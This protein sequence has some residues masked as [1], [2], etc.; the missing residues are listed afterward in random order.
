MKIEICEQ[1]VQ[2]WLINYMN[3][4]VAQ[5]NWSI[6][7][8]KSLDSY[9]ADIDAY[10][11]YFVTALKGGVSQ[12][13]LAKEVLDITQ[14][15]SQ[16]IYRHYCQENEDVS[17]LQFCDMLINASIPIELEKGKVDFSKI[18]ILGKAGK[19]KVMQF[20]R[21]TEI[22]ILGAELDGGKVKNIYLVD[23]AYHKDGLNYSDTLSTVIKKIIRAVLVSDIIFGVDV[24][25]HIVF[26]SPECKPGPQSKII[27][28]KAFIEQHLDNRPTLHGKQSRVTIDVYLNE[29]FSNEIYLP[30]RNRI[31]ELYGGNDLFMR[32]MNLAKIAEKKLP[33]P[34]AT[35]NTHGTNCN[36]ANQ[37]ANVS[38]HNRSPKA[39]NPNGAENGRNS[40][41]EF[42]EFK[43]FYNKG[44][45]LSYCTSIRIIMKEIGVGSLEDLDN[46]IDTA[47][48]YCTNQME[49]PQKID[50]RKKYSDR[51]S[52]LRKYKEFLESR[53]T[54][55]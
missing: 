36:S 29:T 49:N 26:A 16:E 32:S 50:E 54:N 6:S 48:D 39:S 33:A 15:E 30:L 55:P 1:M 8:L 40:T 42:T 35:A 34:S 7:P 22:D 52:A 27:Q 3:C 37:V 18:S 38:N 21:Q 20:V 5:T 25:S 2:S 10:I 43:S 4:H 11:D 23:T 12:G 46:C 28:A 47:I 45:V 19:A 31:D 51:R 9:Q 14:E 41:D 44:S 24:P 17:F 53:K 13:T